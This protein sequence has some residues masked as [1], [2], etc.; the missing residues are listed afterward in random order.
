MNRNPNVP[1]TEL[2]KAP[3][4]AILVGYV[5]PDLNINEYK[6]DLIAVEI[7]DGG[8]HLYKPTLKR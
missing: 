4:N 8:W 6:G 5:S 3:E 7:P 1:E 2:S